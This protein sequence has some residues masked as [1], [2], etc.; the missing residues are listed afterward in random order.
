M[1]AAF[2]AFREHLAKGPRRADVRRYLGAFAPASIGEI[3]GW[4]GI[5]ETTSSGACRNV[6]SPFS[7]R[8]GK[9]LIDLPRSPCGARSTTK[10]SGSRDF[11]VSRNAA[12]PHQDR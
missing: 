7:R 1:E 12:A 2:R 9:D 3:A 5:P 6:P 8:K 10:P 4:A 11:F